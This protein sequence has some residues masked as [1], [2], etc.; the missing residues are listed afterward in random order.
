MVDI[1]VILPIAY[2]RV[3]NN[4]N[5]RKRP[6]PP[7]VRPTHVLLNVMK[8][9]EC[10]LCVAGGGRTERARLLDTT[11]VLEPEPR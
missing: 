10:Q 8:K 2:T 4:Q 9:V 5:N 3:Y 7:N 1:A 11:R 6:P